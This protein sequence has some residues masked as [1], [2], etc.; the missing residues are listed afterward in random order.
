LLERAIMQKIEFKEGLSPIQIKM[1]ASYILILIVVCSAALYRPIFNLLSG[2]NQQQNNKASYTTSYSE[3]V[4]QYNQSQKPEDSHNGVEEQINAAIKPADIGE[5]VI[6][7]AKFEDQLRHWL[8]SDEGV[9]W[10]PNGGKSKSS[11]LLMHVAAPTQG[12]RVVHQKWAKQCIAL[13]ETAAKYRL[14]A[15]VKY[16]EHR[17]IKSTANRVHLYWYD[18]LDCSYGGQYG[19]YLEPDIDQNGWQSLSKKELKP[20]LGARA[21]KIEIV[22]R[23]RHSNGSQ[24]IWDNIVLAP[25]SIKQSKTVDKNLDHSAYTLVTGQNYL[26]NSRFDENLDNWRI[27]SKSDIYLTNNAHDQN[28]GMLTVKTQSHDRS[29]GT[30]AFNQ[31]VNL[32][33]NTRFEFGA[34]ALVSPESTQTG[35]GRLRVTWYEHA[36]CKGRY[37]AA[38]KH[39]D[40]QQNQS[41]WQTLSV[42]SIERVSG[43]KS[44]SVGVTRSINGQGQ[45]IVFWDNMYFKAL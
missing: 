35:G 44:A 10:S 1:K 41:G 28:G 30:G 20:S 39:T 15:H 38:S 37:R 5:N 2:D 4:E 23:Q 11:A 7:N 12:S 14:Q 43:S 25:T 8:F 27:D 31:C 36:N 9:F 16:S 26:L 24:A 6:Q 32:G 18:S 34:N 29:F 40:I 21:A 42:Q 45:H 3:G 17:P 33:D 13:G 22:Q 19:T